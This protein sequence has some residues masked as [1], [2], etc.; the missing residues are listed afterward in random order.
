MCLFSR[1]R[2][3]WLA[4]AFSNPNGI[5][6]KLLQMVSQLIL[7]GLS[8]LYNILKVYRSRSPKLCFFRHGCQNFLIILMMLAK[9]LLQNISQL[10]L[11]GFSVLYDLP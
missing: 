6:Q 9:K 3:K 4:N 8:L 5:G 11:V 1:W 10:I 7:M 2:K